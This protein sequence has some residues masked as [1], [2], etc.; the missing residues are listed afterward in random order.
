MPFARQPNLHRATLDTKK[1]VEVRKHVVNPPLPPPPLLLSLSKY[2]SL[3]LPLS[4][5]SPS[6]QAAGVVDDGRVFERYSFSPFFHRVFLHP[7]FPPFPLTFSLR[8][9]PHSFTNKERQRRQLRKEARAAKKGRRGG[10]VPS[11]AAP[12][13]SA[14]KKTEKQRNEMKRGAAQR[15]GD[16]GDAEGEGTAAKKAKKKKKKNKPSMTERRQRQA[17]ARGKASV[18]QAPSRDLQGINK[19]NARA[20]SVYRQSERA[21]N[22]DQTN[23][24]RLAD[25]LPTVTTPDPLIVCC[26]PPFRS[27][28][29]ALISFPSRFFASRQGKT[30][31]SSGCCKRPI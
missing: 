21:D 6:L 16:T 30:P 8:Y 19:C 25:H 1:L 31:P 7:P 12:L 15:P 20:A 14:K 28:G 4:L 10:Q 3:S 5:I 27:R 13:Q 22:V 29:K 24:L 17:E 18:T 23:M 26:S 9:H 2:L 11:E